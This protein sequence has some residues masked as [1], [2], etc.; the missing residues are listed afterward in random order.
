MPKK[1]SFEN[2]ERVFSHS[3]E[4]FMY[5]PSKITFNQYDKL[6]ANA[7]PMIPI[8]ALNT[9]AQQRVIWKHR[10]ANE[11]NSIGRIKL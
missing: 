10:E 1:T 8:S 11:L 6:M 7:A 4:H 5:N 9:R 2:T 3:E